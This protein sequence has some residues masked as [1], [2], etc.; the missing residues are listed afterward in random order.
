MGGDSPCDWR[1]CVGW[2]HVGC[3]HDGLE[4]FV[5]DVGVDDR[6]SSEDV[7]DLVLNDCRKT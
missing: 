3:T 7:R 4:T 2:V 6:D 1:E 5:G